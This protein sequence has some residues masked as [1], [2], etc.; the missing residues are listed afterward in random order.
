MS[1]CVV[2]C[3]TPAQL[4]LMLTR[5]RRAP[6]CPRTHSRTA[7]PLS[8]LALSLSLPLYSHPLSPSLAL[9][10]L[11]LSMSGYIYF[12]I[13]PS[14]YSPFYPPL[15]IYLPISL[16]RSLSSGSYLTH[17]ASGLDAHGE[18]QDA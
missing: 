7:A 2:L 9:V 11:Y 12:S 1:L 6:L 10:A 17:E 14:L 4:S 5:S 18:G 13:Y 8:V 3:C 16:S 15:S